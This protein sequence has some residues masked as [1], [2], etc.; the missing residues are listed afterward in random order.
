MANGYFFAPLN[1]VV[2]LFIKPEFGG[3]T[4]G[5]AGALGTGAL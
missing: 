5:L 3:G 2:G 4:A 1:K